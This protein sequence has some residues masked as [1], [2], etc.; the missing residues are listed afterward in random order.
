MLQASRRIA[1]F[2]R[3]RVPYTVGASRESPVVEISLTAGGGPRLLAVG[4]S[5]ESAEHFTLDETALYTALAD[6]R[7]IA[8]ALA[9]SGTH[10]REEIPIF[11]R[12]GVKR[13]AILAGADGS[14][15]LPFQLDSPF[16]GLLEER[17]QAGRSRASAIATGGYYTVRP[18]LPRT[19]QLA[20]RRRFRRIQE[21]STFP[22]WPIETALHRLEALVL[23]LVQRVAGEPLPWLAPWPAPYGWALRPHPRRRAGGWLR[24]RQER[25]ES[26]A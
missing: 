16:E 9:E 1:L 26:R 10:W 2:E 25:P 17:Y 7:T 8:S 5:P 18:L 14:V 22:G 19:V 12:R 24:E 6:E 21:R 13:S 23:S 4:S 11:D 20:I 3:Y 15:F